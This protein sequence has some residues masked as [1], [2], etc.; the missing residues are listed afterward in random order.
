MPEVLL[1]QYSTLIFFLLALGVV[2]V[3]FAHSHL[4]SK[5]KPNHPYL[6]NPLMV[7]P[8]TELMPIEELE[9][10]YREALAKTYDHYKQTFDDHTQKAEAEFIQYLAELQVRA[11]QTDNLIESVKKERIDTLFDTLEKRLASVI[12]ETVKKTL[13]TIEKDLEDSHQAVQDYTNKQLSLID[14]NAIDLLEKTLSIVLIKKMS[15][16]DQLDLVYEALEKAKLEKFLSGSQMAA[17]PEQQVD[18]P[19]V[20]QTIAQGQQTDITKIWTAAM[21]RSKPS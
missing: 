10:Y 6:A 13:S 18:T 12:D 17:M 7:D 11:Q 19:Q 4:S 14:Q 21:P 9:G 1:S 8:K 15:L 2:V 16:R 3:M 5:K 20:D